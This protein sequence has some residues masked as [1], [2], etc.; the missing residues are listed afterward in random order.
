MPTPCGDDTDP[1][2]SVT[3]QGSVLSLEPHAG[4]TRLYSRS[5]EV[6]AGILRDGIRGLY[7]PPQTKGQGH[8]PQS[9]NFPQRLHFLWAPL[10][11]DALRVS[12]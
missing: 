12:G 5:L 9:L 7:L 4:V 3:G 11:A 6:H 8:S 10:E 1:T 2:S